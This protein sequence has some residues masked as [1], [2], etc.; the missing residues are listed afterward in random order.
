MAGYSGTSLEQKLGIKAGSRLLLV[1][2]P[3]DVHDTA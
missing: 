2:A 3:D 1:G